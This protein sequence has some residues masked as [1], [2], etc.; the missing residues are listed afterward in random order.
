MLRSRTPGGVIQE[1]YGFACVHYAI[2]WLLHQAALGGN[3]DEGRLSFTGGLRAIRRK[4]SRPERVSPP[5]TRA[6][7]IRE[8]IHEIL[9]APNP[10]RLRS[11]PRVVKRAV[12][13]DPPKRAKHGGWPQPTK[14]PSEAVIILT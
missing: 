10:A 3:V 1:L 8:A 7:L 11:C 5:T 2:R 12:T 13:Y 4:R 14:T 6:K 9:S